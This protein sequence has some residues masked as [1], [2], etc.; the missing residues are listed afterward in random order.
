[1]IKRFTFSKHEKLCG[2][3]VVTN[4]FQQGSSFISYPLRVVWTMVEAT[5]E[6]SLKVLMSVP[7]KKLKHAVDRNRIKRLLREAYRLHKQELTEVVFDRKLEVRLA[8]IWLP[9]E[10]EEFSKV[11]IKVQKALSTLQRLL[12][13]TKDPDTIDKSTAFKIDCID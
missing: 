6:P 10:T 9:M 11:E 3:T 7:K 8:M 1:M 4:L 2:E 13:E 5:G 12:S